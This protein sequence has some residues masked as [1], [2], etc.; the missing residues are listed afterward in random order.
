YKE[1]EVGQEI[2]YTIM[3]DAVTD[4][5]TEVNSFDV[6]NTHEPETIEITGSKTW[7]DADNQDGK[8]PESITIR[9]YA[10]GVELTDRI[11]TVT[12]IDDWSWTF[13][14]LPKYKEGEVG[15]EII[16]TI[17]ED[18]VIDYTTEVNGFDVTN[19]HTPETI[20]VTGS[21]TWDD[22]DNR[23]GKRPES[24]TIR[25]YAD[26]TE[27]TD[28]AKTITAIDDWSWSFENLPK[29]KEGEVGQ[30]I[31]YTIMED[32]VTDYTT[33]VN[34]FDV[35]NTHE[36]ETIE[37][38]GSKTWDDADNQ[39]GKRPES[40]T[41]RLYADGV[42]LTEKAQTVTPD[43]D[44]N[45]TWTFEDLP[46]YKAGEVGQEIVYTIMED[47]VT[48]YSTEVNGF[49]VT[50]SY[51]PGKTSANVTKVWDDRNDQDGIRPKEITIKLLADGKDTGMR[52]TLSAE[53]NW[54]A[55][56]TELDEYMGG[57]M[58][59]YTIEEVNVTGYAT[60]ITGDASTGYIITNAHTPKAI[61]T[62]DSKTQV[63]ADKR[64]GKRPRTGDDNRLTL[65]IIL[66]TLSGAAAVGTEAWSRKRRGKRNAR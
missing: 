49:D 25:L 37:I 28:R 44:D 52:L 40:I 55:T 48:D 51:T 50:N 12:A 16:Y 59:V 9:L 60:K 34:S 6:T 2:I 11:K 56:F 26:G 41:I 29:Y 18:A 8:R 46:K 15:Q 24:I 17:T 13:E 43:E 14:N 19:T 63:D 27:L 38:T 20:E 1:G 61:G 45:W 32:A 7:D 35:T 31:I 57:I 10:D 47:A 3:E 5:T 33:E 39:D 54:Q 42:E 23:D 4:Y 36:P 65:W 64:G 53:N 21:K 30:E 58:I 62:P 22:D 66:F